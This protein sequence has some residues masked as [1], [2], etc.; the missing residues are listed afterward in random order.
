MTNYMREINSPSKKIYFDKC[1]N[2]FYISPLTAC[3][4]GIFVTINVAFILKIFNYC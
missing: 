3:I 1:N 2:N 4:I